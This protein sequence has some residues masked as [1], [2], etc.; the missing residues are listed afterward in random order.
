MFLLLCS[1]VCWSFYL[2]M[3]HIMMLCMLTS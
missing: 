1:C 2:L 3:W